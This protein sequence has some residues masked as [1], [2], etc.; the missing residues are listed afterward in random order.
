M[1]HTWLKL[2]TSLLWSQKFR[3]LPDNDHRIV[4]ICHLIFAKMGLENESISWLAATSFVT[5][6]RYKIIV[7]NLVGCGLFDADGHV[8]GFEDSQLTPDAYR[9]R[10]QREREKSRDGHADSHAGNPLDS[11]KQKAESS[12]AEKK[13]PPTPQNPKTARPASIAAAA[14][15]VQIIDIINQKFGLKRS[16]TP[17]LIR[18]VEI[19]LR[20]G[21]TSDDIML[22]VGNRLGNEDW[23]DPRKYG[24][25]SLIRRDK[26]PSMLQIAK[27]APAAYDPM[28][29]GFEKEPWK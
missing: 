7:K 29:D 11:R 28:K 3:G 19:L 13:N 24:A 20:A 15:A 16:A 6:Y 17:T 25:E 10:R 23:F 8:N 4:Y 9:K 12:P 27:D 26:F 18:A 5:K 22:V 2:L 14:V 1:K 21:H